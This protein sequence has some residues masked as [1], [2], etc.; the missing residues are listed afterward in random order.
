MPRRSPLPPEL[1][2]APFHVREADALD[3]GRSRLRGADLTAPFRGVRTAAS[4]PDLVELCH[5]YAARM[6]QGHHF[7][8]VTAARLWGIPLPAEIDERVHV[9]AP[10]PE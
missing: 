9:T 7:S 2:L 10:Y 8:D 3:V 1:L 5:T 4:T 6:P